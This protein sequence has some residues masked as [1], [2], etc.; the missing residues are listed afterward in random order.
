MK[1]L[2]VICIAAAAVA[3][4][5]IPSALA[6]VDVCSAPA[7]ALPLGFPSLT[8]IVGSRAW[9]DGSC[10]GTGVVSI[11]TGSCA[12]PVGQRCL[13]IV[14]AG[15][16]IA[17]SWDRAVG[18]SVIGVAIGVDANGDENIFDHQDPAVGVDRSGLTLTGHAFTWQVPATGTIIVYPVSWLRGGAPGDVTAITCLGPGGL[19]L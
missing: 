15:T 10:Q 19:P 2:L 1:R 12:S 16:V 6:G 8:P 4:P 9:M 18:S 17:C 3:L 11:S 13:G 7:Q 14:A 5:A